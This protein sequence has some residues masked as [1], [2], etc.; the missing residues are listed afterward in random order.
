MHYRT[1]TRPQQWAVSWMDGNPESIVDDG[2]I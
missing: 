1:K 2:K